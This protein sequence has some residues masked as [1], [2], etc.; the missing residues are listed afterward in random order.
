M[1]RDRNLVLT[2]HGTGS[3]WEGDVECCGISQTRKLVPRRCARVITFLAVV[4]GL[5]A[6]ASAATAQPLIGVSV[7]DVTTQA[8]VRN[9][10][11]VRAGDQFRVAVVNLGAPCAGQYTVTDL[12]VPGYPLSVLVQAQSFIIGPGNSRFA[13]S[14]LPTTPRPDVTND[15][16]V[17]ASC[18]GAGRGEITTATPFEFFVGRGP[19]TGPPLAVDLIVKDLTT[20]M[21]IRSGQTVPANDNFQVY[22]RYQ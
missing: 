17:T 1:R 14:M 3:A 20:G 21:N 18:N 16:K 19:A 8:L 6:F 9:G 12:G 10:Q 5:L 4:I 13:G 22:C 7:R 15:F 11:I 2:V